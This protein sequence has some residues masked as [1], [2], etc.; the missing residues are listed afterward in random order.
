MDSVKKIIKE[1]RITDKNTNP[2]SVS[3]QEAERLIFEQRR[4]L[5]AMNPNAVSM[6]DREL[7]NEH[8]QK[9]KLSIEKEKDGDA[10]KLA[11]VKLAKQISLVELYSPNM[12]STQRLYDYPDQIELEKREYIG[13]AHVERS[14]RL[15]ITVE[16]LV[17][18]LFE[19]SLENLPDPRTDLKAFKQK[20]ED[21][22][23][24]TTNPFQI[25]LRGENGVF[26]F[27]IFVTLR[28]RL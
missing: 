25:D 24:K 3:R 19:N 7:A 4:L 6:V 14:D 28:A 16:K 12:V 1:M 22:Y 18:P 2:E 15:R 11:K 21:E 10:E 8:A 5:Y 26:L 9:I 27:S 23:L 13:S 20:F 17:T